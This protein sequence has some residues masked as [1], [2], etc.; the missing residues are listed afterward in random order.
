M[1]RWQG[2]GGSRQL[3][4]PA[5]RLL[6]PDL[7]GQR[8]IDAGKHGGTSFENAV[9]AGVGPSGILKVD[10]E[11][12]G[13]KNTKDWLDRTSG[14]LNYYMIISFLSH[15]SSFFKIALIGRRPDRV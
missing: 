4:L 9:K 11:T 12:N 15:H 14:I 10:F 3:L 6:L 5:Y 1:G 7:G 8:V 2:A 13:Q